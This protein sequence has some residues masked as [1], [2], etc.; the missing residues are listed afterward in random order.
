MMSRPHMPQSW[1]RSPCLTGP[2]SAGQVNHVL[3]AAPCALPSDPYERSGL[4]ARK[5]RIGDPYTSAEI[6]RDLTWRQRRGLANARDVQLLQQ[7]T[8][9]LSDWLAAYK[10]IK[11]ARA[12]ERIRGIVERTVSLFC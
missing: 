10:G 7:A 9:A 5:L 8:C 12:R 2:M 11:R 1:Q 4:V 3:C 6:V